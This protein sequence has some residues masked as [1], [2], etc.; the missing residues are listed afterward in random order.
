MKKMIIVTGILSAL[1]VIA[2]AVF[3]FVPVFTGVL[4]FNE[5]LQ[6]SFE[7]AKLVFT[8]FATKT[9]TDW[10]I[11][12]I[13]VLIV[14]IFIAMIITSIVK[15]RGAIFGLSFLTLLFGAVSLYVFIYTFQT[16]LFDG[17]PKEWYTYVQ[18]GFSLAGLLSTACFSIVVML[19]ERK[20]ANNTP[21]NLAA[22]AAENPE[23]EEPEEKVIEEP[24][25]E[26]VEEPQ[27][28]VETVKQMEEE[29]EEEPVA[30]VHEVEEKVVS[31]LSE[32]PQPVVA[33]VEPLPKENK[34]EAPEAKQ[35]E[36]EEKPAPKAEKVEEP[37]E[38]NKTDKVYHVSKRQADGKWTIKFAKGS[39]VIK[40]F[41]TKE[42]AVQYAYEL[43]DKQN[44]R[45]AIHASKGKNKGRITSLE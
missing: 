41:N 23:V 22:V 25:E 18:F 33:A 12:A 5:L 16:G 26:K 11:F 9:P 17:N 4:V 10:V 3:F 24:K 37:K 13:A 35:E 29:P 21:V 43:A 8:N 15:K 28:V 44:A 7:L 27:P 1:L 14:V 38:E 20:Q 39:K 19:L 6:G 36:P 40:T 2:S 32:E 30:Q 45:V 31:P 34:V 42:E